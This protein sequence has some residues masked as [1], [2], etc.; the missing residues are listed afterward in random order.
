MIFRLLCIYKTYTY[1]QKRRGLE[2]VAVAPSYYFKLSHEPIFT[3]MNGEALDI[4]DLTW[5][6]MR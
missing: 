6:M 2:Q 5:V 1:K 3:R 4:I